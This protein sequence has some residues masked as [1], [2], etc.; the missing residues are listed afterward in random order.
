MIFFEATK[1]TWKTNAQIRSPG[2]CHGENFPI[3][4]TTGKPALAQE[5]NP[6]SWKDHQGALVLTNLQ[7]V[8][9]V[10]LDKVRKGLTS[11]FNFVLATK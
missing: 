1:N 10:T 2:S 8:G 4:G 5:C 6:R 3:Q 11:I 9:C 7:Y